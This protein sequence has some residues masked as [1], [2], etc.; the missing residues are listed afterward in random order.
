MGFKPFT[1]QG[2]APGFEFH[3]DYGSP[4]PGGG[5]CG[6]ILSQPLLLALMLAFSPLPR[7]R[8]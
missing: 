2:E 8:F 3:T 4:C 7:A 5:V 1:N 6:E